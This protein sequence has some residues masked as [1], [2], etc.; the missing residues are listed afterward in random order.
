MLSRE[1][2]GTVQLVHPTHRHGDFIHDIPWQDTIVAALH[3]MDLAAVTAQRALR[4]KA[5]ALAVDVGT[6]AACGDGETRAAAK[7]PVSAAA[8]AAAVVATAATAVEEV[9]ELDVSACVA[10]YP[11][12]RRVRGGGGDS[13]TGVHHRNDSAEGTEGMGSARHMVLRNRKVVS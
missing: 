3:T 6:A 10:S 5:A 12:A 11:S 4:S 13:E 7:A 9:R 1:S 2:P 8:A